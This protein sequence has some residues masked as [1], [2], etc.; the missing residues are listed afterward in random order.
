MLYI[1]PT[2]STPAGISAS[3]DLSVSAVNALIKGSDT[4][5]GASA[6][7]AATGGLAMSVGNLTLQGGAASG[8]HAA[9]DPAYIDI[10]AA[11]DIKLLGGAGTD[12]HA[13][14][15]TPTGDIFVQAGGNIQ[16]QQGTGSGAHAVIAAETGA[17]FM[18]AL[19][20]QNCGVLFV[21]PISGGQVNATGVYGTS[22]DIQV[23]QGLASIIDQTL[24]NAVL[25]AIQLA[26]QEGAADLLEAIAGGDATALLADNTGTGEGKRNA[27]NKAPI[28]D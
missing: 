15:V 22:S 2:G 7:L 18:S 9:I 3:G 28:C 6:K 16:L 23:Q 11:G 27:R 1:E 26:T 24:V 20:C 8:A 5:A 12:S 13:S 14:I 25:A 4:F 17:V 21:N 10:S 19:E